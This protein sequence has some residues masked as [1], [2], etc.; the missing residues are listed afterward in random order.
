MIE[1]LLLILAAIGTVLAMV[2]LALAFKK[3]WKQVCPKYENG[4][5]II[6][7]RSAATI[8][9]LLSAV[10]CFKADHPS[11]AVLVW[12]MLLPVSTMMVAI[13]LSTRPALLRFFCPVFFVRKRFNY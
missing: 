1:A 2:W 7:L 11:M 9:L 13:T 10:C 3:H 12:I 6:R 4:P 5:H 8:L